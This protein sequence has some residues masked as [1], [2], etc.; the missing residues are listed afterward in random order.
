MMTFVETEYRC[1][2]RVGTPDL[3]SSK[4]RRN[5]M[6]LE[7]GIRQKVE[8]NVLSLG[9]NL[10]SECKSVQRIKCHFTRYPT[11]VALVAPST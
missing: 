5:Q 10:T 6:A 1:L 2:S 9:I 3:G 11:T 8:D 7:N 4:S